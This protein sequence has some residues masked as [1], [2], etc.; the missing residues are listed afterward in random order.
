MVRP[1][2]NLNTSWEFFQNAQLALE[3]MN[4]VMQRLAAV[5]S[6]DHPIQ[7]SPTDV[8][9]VKRNVARFQEQFALLARKQKREAAR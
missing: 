4:A 3:N 1:R 7:I 8:H 9:E 6:A 2:K 5:V